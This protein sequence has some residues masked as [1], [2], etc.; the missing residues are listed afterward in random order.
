MTSPLAP[1]PRA[2]NCDCRARKLAAAETETAPGGPVAGTNG[3]GGVA[4][5]S[6]KKKVALL[7]SYWGSDYQGL[8][9]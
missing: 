2:G 8:Q 1:P 7:I 4:S 3:E 9:M 5:S 6:S